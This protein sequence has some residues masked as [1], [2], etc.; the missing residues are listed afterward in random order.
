MKK[1]IA[2]L[3]ALTTAASLSVT[4]FAET[5]DNTNPAPATPASI[6]FEKD[7]NG[8]DINTNAVLTPGKTYY[9]P[10]KYIA[11]GKTAAEAEAL[12]STQF[13]SLRFRFGAEEGK[14]TIDAIKVE[15]Y[16]SIY[17]L[18]VKVKA[19]WPT[20]LTDVAYETSVVDIKN[21]DKAVASPALSFQTGYKAIDENTIG[22]HEYV[23]VSP[24]APVITE[25]TFD[26]L[27]DMADGKEITFANDDWEYAVRVNGMKDINMVS[28]SDEIDEIVE[29]YG[30]NDFKFVSFP[31]GPEFRSTGVLTVDVSSEMSSF[32]GKFFVY[33]YLSGKLTK[34]DA[35]LDTDEETLALKTKQL[36]RFV[37]TNKELKGTTVVENGGSSSTG[38]TTGEDSGTGTEQN[39]DTGAN[40]FVGLASVAALIAVAGIAASRKRK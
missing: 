5:T 9:F 10:V 23:S 14:Q 6:I 30:D 1:L 25:D 4:A 38:G 15:K 29:K 40:D 32:E 11:E 12:T 31:G 8:V 20:K 27:N 34:M 2:M 33:R 3:L 17:S 16:K 19:G 37:I 36:G 21:G 24:S 28:N 26:A 22:N 39:P 13:N 18:S 7:T 35:T